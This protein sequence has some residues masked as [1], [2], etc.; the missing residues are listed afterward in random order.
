MIDWLP[1]AMWLL[2]GGVLIALTRSHLR[3]AVVLLT[4]IGGNLPKWLVA[5]GFDQIPAGRMAMFIIG[6]VGSF[7]ANITAPLLIYLKVDDAVGAT[8]VHG[9]KRKS[10]PFLS[11]IICC[12]PIQS[13]VL[14]SFNVPIF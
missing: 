7:L 2:L 13:Y 12:M 10:L 5:A 6:L 4:A 14:C 1:P 9:R 3:A 11:I 8:C